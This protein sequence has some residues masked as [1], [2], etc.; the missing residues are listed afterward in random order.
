MAGMRS[1]DVGGIADF[2]NGPEGWNR[3]SGS[4]VEVEAGACAGVS[5]SAI[6]H[7]GANV[8]ACKI[9]LAVWCGFGFSSG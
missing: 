5:L 4:T 8:G 2:A 9:T 3:P 7:D 1:C 6:A